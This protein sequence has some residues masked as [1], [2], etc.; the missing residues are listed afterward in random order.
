MLY[1]DICEYLREKN[2]FLFF[3]IFNGRIVLFFSEL[4]RCCDVVF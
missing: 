2:I 4:I 1:N 3:V